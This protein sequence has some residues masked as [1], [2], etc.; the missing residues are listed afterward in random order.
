MYGMVNEAIRTMILKVGGQE[1]W[2]EIAKE[3]GVDALHGF[4]TFEQYDDKVT[5]DLVTNTSKILEI[6]P[7]KLLEK[8]GIFWVEYAKE[9]EYSSILSTA[10]SDPI[11][12][13]ENLDS[14]HKR[15]ELAFDN[16]N[17]PSFW[18][19]DIKD[20]ELKLFYSSQRDMP[21]EYFV[22]GLVKGIFFMFDSTCEIQ[23]TTP[24]KEGVVEF[25][26][27]FQT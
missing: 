15:L 4:N 1:K 7:T 3:V 18:V 19:E 8:F 22:L 27:T 24:K 11:E 12:L 10:A 26:V 2:N 16:L 14:L 23:I 13:L 21:L 9:S 5:L 17:A 20:H 6:E 25:K